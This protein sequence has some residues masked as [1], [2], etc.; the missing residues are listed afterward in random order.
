MIPS[1]KCRHGFVQICREVARQKKRLGGDFAV[2]HLV[3]SKKSRELCRDLNLKPFK[4]KFM[5]NCILIIIECHFKD[6]ILKSKVS[7]Q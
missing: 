1:S 3:M 7:D 5:K 4:L 6:D 2:A